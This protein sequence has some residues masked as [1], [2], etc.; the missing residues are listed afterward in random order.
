[1]ACMEHLCIGC[2]ELVFN[3]SRKPEHPC[4]KCGGTRWASQFD[5]PPV[6][7]EPDIENTDDDYDE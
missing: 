3:N 2:G 1:M 5:E 6:E 7:K 4:S